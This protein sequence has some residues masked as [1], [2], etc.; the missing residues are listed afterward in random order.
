MT[1]DKP[2]E[3]E[4]R[5]NGFDAPGSA[6]PREESPAPGKTH[7]TAPS[8]KTEK[9]KEGFHAIVEVAGE[10]ASSQSI[11]DAAKDDAVAAAETGSSGEPVG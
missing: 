10:D 7:D 5:P 2:S 4:S 9:D 3:P 8:T 6:A 11:V 1:S